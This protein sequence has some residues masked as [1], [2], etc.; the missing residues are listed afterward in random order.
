MTTSDRINFLTA[1]EISTC[2]ASGAISSVQ[3]VTACLDQIDKHNW[4]GRKLK[5]LVAVAPRDV[6]LK[7]AEE[8]DGERRAGR[9]RSALHGV[10]IVLKVRYTA[11][12]A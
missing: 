3:L 5:A 12:E 9:V 8:L 4:Q 11:T 1:S 10:P 2:L 6:A 7:R